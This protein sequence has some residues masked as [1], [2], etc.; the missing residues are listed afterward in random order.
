MSQEN[1]ES[2]FE[3]GVG[4]SPMLVVGFINDMVSNMVNQLSDEQVD[5]MYDS[6]GLKEGERFSF[7]EIFRILNFY[8]LA[9]DEAYSYNDEYSKNYQAFVDWAIEQSKAPDAQPQHDIQ[10]FMKFIFNLTSPLQEYFATYTFGGDRDVVNHLSLLPPIVRYFVLAELYGKMAV[11]IVSGQ[12]VDSD[13]ARNLMDRYSLA[14]LKTTDPEIAQDWVEKN[15]FVLDQFDMYNICTDKIRVLGEKTVEYTT[16]SQAYPVY[17][18]KWQ[19]GEG[20]QEKSLFADRVSFLY[21]T[22][23]LA[24]NLLIAE[25]C[26]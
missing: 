10:S 18:Q 16:F 11:Q 5:K 13:Y 25:L 15:K 1:L 22:P 7:A 20:S 17:K 21:Q 4:I 14:I 8:T 26:Q 24:V 9:M 19:L 3:K 2:K 23:I 12:E 6:F